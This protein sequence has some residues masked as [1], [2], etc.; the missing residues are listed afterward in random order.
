MV[1][2][3]VIANTLF[4]VV[5][6]ISTNPTGRL[7]VTLRH[8]DGSTDEHDV[9]DDIGLALLR[10]HGAALQDLVGNPWRAILQN[11]PQLHGAG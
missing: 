10:A 2:V 5:A 6:A 9:A 8:E 4:P 3:C 1:A 11:L 7:S